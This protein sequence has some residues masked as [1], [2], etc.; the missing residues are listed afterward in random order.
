[1]SGITGVRIALGWLILSASLVIFSE[2]SAFAAC[3]EKCN[4]GRCW[5]MSVQCYQYSRTI[6]FPENTNVWALTGGGKMKPHPTLKYKLRTASA[7]MKECF[8]KNDSRAHTI[9]PPPDSDGNTCS[10]D[11]GPWGP[12]ETATYCGEDS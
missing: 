6:A 5:K 9:P 10:G 7:C 4:E 8:D 2:A 3:V 11:F 1:M 12:E